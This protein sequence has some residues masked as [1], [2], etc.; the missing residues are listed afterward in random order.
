MVIH[1]FRGLYMVLE[2]YTWLWRVMHGG[3][4]WL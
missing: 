3:Y 1:G 4:T 2:G